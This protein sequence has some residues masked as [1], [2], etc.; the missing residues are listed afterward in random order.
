[1]REQ[2]NPFDDIRDDIRLARE[3]RSIDFVYLA[4]EKL[5]A[6]VERLSQEK[7]A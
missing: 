5:T 1:M 2:P 3:H 4:L 7:G 6:E